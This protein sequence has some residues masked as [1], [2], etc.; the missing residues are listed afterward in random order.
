MHDGGSDHS[1]A[2]GGR[3][4]R[5]DYKERG[6]AYIVSVGLPRGARV[7]MDG[8]HVKMHGLDLLA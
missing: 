6:K 7:K 2:R 8:M 3:P 5:E 1:I 4:E